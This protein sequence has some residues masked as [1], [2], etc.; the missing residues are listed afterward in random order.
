MGEHKDGLCGGNKI[1]STSNAFLNSLLGD[2][3]GNKRCSHELNVLSEDSFKI[4]FWKN[5]HK[6]NCEDF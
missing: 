1:N 6:T 4:T 5:P 2:I 3:W